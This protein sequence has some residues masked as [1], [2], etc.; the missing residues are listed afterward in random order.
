MEKSMRNTSDCPHEKE[1]VKK[2]SMTVGMYLGFYAMRSHNPE[3]QKRTGEMSVEEA[4]IRLADLGWP[5][6]EIDGDHTREISENGGRKRLEELRR[7]CDERG[8][9]IRHLHCGELAPGDYETN[10]GFIEHA[11]LLGISYLVLHPGWSGGYTRKRERDRLLR[12]ETAFLERLAEKAARAGVGLTLENMMR[13]GE[14]HRLGE[15]IEDLLELVD[16]VG[17]PS[18][19]IC[20]DTSHA[21]A[22]GFDVAETVHRCGELLWASHVSGNTGEGDGHRIPYNG[23]YHL[24]SRNRIDWIEVMKAYRRVGYGGMLSLEIPGDAVSPLAVRDLKLE[25][26][27]KLLLWLLEQ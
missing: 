20:L 21:N 27:R 25:Y 18:L 5:D 13:K 7:T 4:V 11:R 17:S 22:N 8:I 1:T 10:A 19:G 23:S 15:T 14:V 16:A 24:Y 26:A 12:D 3:T 6:L 9:R 2:Q